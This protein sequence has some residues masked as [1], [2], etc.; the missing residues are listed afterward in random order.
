MP[1]K[2]LLQAPRTLGPASISGSHKG[3]RSHTL[4]RMAL[5]ARQQALLGCRVRPLWPKLPPM[6]YRAPNTPAHWATAGSRPL[7]SRRMLYHLRDLCGAAA[8]RPQV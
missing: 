4:L 8:C 1:L 7:Q 5:L 2:T 6:I 3:S